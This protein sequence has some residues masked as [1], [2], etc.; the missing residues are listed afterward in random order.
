[1]ETV[2]AADREAVKGRT[3]YDDGYFS[4]LY[5]K[6]GPVMEQR[7]SGAITAVA[8]LITSAWTDA[9]KPALPADNP[10]RTPRPIRR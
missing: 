6:A 5:E 8:S 7:M 2:L 3:E 9:G 1:V 4:V 10:P